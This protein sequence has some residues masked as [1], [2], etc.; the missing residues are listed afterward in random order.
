MIYSNQ[1][2]KQFF[3]NSVLESL[4]Q[5]KMCIRVFRFLKS[6]Y[7]EKDMLKTVLLEK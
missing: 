7:W 4:V 2:L 3:K 5:K 1:I 6:A